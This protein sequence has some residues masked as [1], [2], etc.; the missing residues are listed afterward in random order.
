MLTAARNELLTRV[1]P[2][3]PMGELL[4]RYWQ[5]IGGASE[6]DKQADQADAADGREPRALQGQ[7]RHVRPGRPALRASA[8][9]SCLRLGRGQRHPLQLPRLAVRRDRRVP[10][11][12]LRGH[13]QPEA[14][15]GRLRREGLSGARV[16]GLAV[17]LHGPAARARTAGV[18]AVHLGER[19]PRDRARRRAVQLVPVPRRTRSTRCISNGCTTTGASGCAAAT[20]PRRSISSSSSRSS[21]TASSTSACARARARRTA[22]GPSAA[23]R[24]GRT[25]STSAAISNGACRSTTRTRCRW[26]GS[27][28]ACRRAAS[29]TCR[30]AC[31]PGRARSGARTAA[32]SPATSSTRT[33]SPGSGRARSPTARAR[34]CARAT[35]ASP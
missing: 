33:S 26:R 7:A 29:P 13:D 31:R 34:T 24:C 3:T 18:G 12:A 8:R 30:T 35:S 28:C 32:G 19:L 22:T 6:L 9:R 5:P 23:S 15:E 20:R 27:S 2:G 10:R 21:T 16:A 25:A 1:G 17:G 4:R 14:L 11:A